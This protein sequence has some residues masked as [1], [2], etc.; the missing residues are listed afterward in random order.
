MLPPPLSRSRGA[1]RRLRENGTTRFK[2]RPNSN[3]SSVCSA[4]GTAYPDT[5]D[6]PVNAALL[7]RMSQAP[8]CSTSFTAFA[9]CSRSSRSAPTATWSASPGK[10]RAASSAPAWS[11]RITRAPADA[12]AAHSTEPSGPAPPVTTAVRPHKSANAVPLAPPQ[13]S[14]GRPRFIAQLD[15]RDALAQCRRHAFAESDRVLDIAEL[16][17]GEER[18]RLGCHHPVPVAVVFVHGRLMAPDGVRDGDRRLCDVPLHAAGSAADHDAPR[19]RARDV[20]QPHRDGCAVGGPQEGRGLVGTDVER[21][22]MIQ[23][24]AGQPR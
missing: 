12:S 23:N 9:S 20:V 2:R 21:T 3:A 24:G 10:D 7:T 22:V 14:I 13:P 19:T 18:P 8:T 5:P 6:V 17:V 16:V 11:M 4:N 15:H 1:S